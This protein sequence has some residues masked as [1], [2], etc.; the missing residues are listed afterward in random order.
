MLIF[1]GKHV[2]YIKVAYAMK[3]VHRNVRSKK[4]NV[5]KEVKKYLFHKAK[6]SETF[7][8]NPSSVDVN[9]TLVLVGSE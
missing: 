1:F 3:H 6:I 4:P 5:G 8:K 2:L 9:L 7:D